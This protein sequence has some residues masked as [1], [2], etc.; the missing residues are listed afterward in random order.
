MNVLFV[1]L[2]SIGRRHLKNLC[3]VCKER[4]IN[5]KIDALRSSDNKLPE[6]IE[7]LIN[8]QIRKIEDNI[9]YDLVFI[10]N[11]TVFH[12]DT[13]NQLKDTCKFFFIEKP[14][15]HDD[16]YSLDKLGL[17][18][19]NAYVAAPI[20][21]SKTYKKLKE[22]LRDINCYCTRIIC[23]SYLP[24]WRTNVDYRD[25][26]SA[27]RSLGGGVSIDLIH[28]IDYMVDLFGFPLEIYNFKGK[29]SNLEIDSEDISVYIAKYKDKLCEVH[30]DYFGREYMR[31]CEVFTESGTVIADFGKKII[32]LPNGNIIDC[33]CDD[34]DNYIN[35]INYTLELIDKNI[36]NINEP[37]RALKVLSL[38]LGR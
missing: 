31:I 23:S 16:N 32:K 38:T 26:Y 28:E 7:I 36:D 33:S 6:E 11:P 2:G 4:N 19:N 10:T 21:H 22:I 24:N 35:E 9:L 12:Y 14:I 27:K 29:C 20:R 5:V 25:S 17:N 15:F 1:G 30:L 37:K 34:N 8:N 3:H 13:I 18:K